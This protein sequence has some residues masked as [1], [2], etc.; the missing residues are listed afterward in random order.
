MQEEHVVFS[1]TCTM[2]LNIQGSES[3]VSYLL[4]ARMISFHLLKIKWEDSIVFSF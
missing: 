4:F 2:T 3:F 1:G